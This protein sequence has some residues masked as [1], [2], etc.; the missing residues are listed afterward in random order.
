MV[1]KA[2][3]LIIAAAFTFTSCNKSEGKPESIRSNYILT[4]K[5][6]VKK[7]V[8]AKNLFDY[9]HNRSGG[10]NPDFRVETKDGKRVA[11]I[12]SY[13]LMWATEGSNYMMT[14]KEA[15]EWLKSLNSKKYAGYSNWRLPTI[16]EAALLLRKELNKDKLFTYDIFSPVQRFIW[17]GDSYSEN[18]MWAVSFS[19]GSITTDSINGKEYVRPVRK[20]N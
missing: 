20:I 13:R 18:I 7:A 3:I 12:S 19:F 14:F 9:R 15:G 11:V 16:E 17:T 2:L 8:N 5:K 6:S 4:G 1:I 10:F